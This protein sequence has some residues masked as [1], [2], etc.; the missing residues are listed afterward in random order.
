MAM[1]RHVPGLLASNTIVIESP[2]GTRSVS[3]SA[4]ARLAPVIAI[5]WKWWPC[6]RIGCDI[7]DALRMVISM[8][9]RRRARSSSPP[10]IDQA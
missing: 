4:P 3:R 8:R 6:R 2:G 1:Q 7:V 9:W 5:T 10:S